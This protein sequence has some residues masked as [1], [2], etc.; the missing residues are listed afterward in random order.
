MSRYE[1]N[2]QLLK[3]AVAFENKNPLTSF[4]GPAVGAILSGMTIAELVSDPVKGTKKTMDF[5]REIDEECGGLNCLNSVPNGMNMTVAISLLWCSRV[6]IPGIDIGENTVWQVKEKRI[7]GPD[8]YDEIL[9][10]G[11]SNFVNQKILPKIIDLDYMGKYFKIFAEN[12]L[13]LYN[14]YKEMGYP[15]TADARCPATSIPFESLS[16]LRS[17]PELLYDCYTQLD[18]VKEVCDAIFEEKYAESETGLEKVKDN[19]DIIANWIG[20]WR[21]ASAM[22]SPKIWDTL[23]WP[24]MKKSAEQMTRFG[25]IAVMHLDQNWNRDIERF[26]ELEEGKYILN[27][28][29]MTDLRAARKKLPRTCFMGDVPATLLTAGKPEQVADYVTRLIDDIGPKGLIITAGCDIPE[30]ATR[31]NIVAMFKAANE[32]S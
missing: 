23:V 13:M 12:H 28:D 25:K 18:K 5:I 8:Q 1:N 29:G 9:K 19:K 3:D 20:G 32:W 22:V 2:Y 27:T 30:S 17:M 11:F 10:M 16:G 14:E 15:M 31:E 24:Y 7:V 6:L 21:T 4:S 26:G